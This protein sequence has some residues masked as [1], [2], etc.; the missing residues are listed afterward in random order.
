CNGRLW[1]RA[2]SMW[3]VLH[4]ACSQPTVPMQPYPCSHPTHAATQPTSL[5]KATQPMQ[6]YQ[7]MQPAYP[8]YPAYPAVMR[9]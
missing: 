4:S 6:P 9:T 5:Q 1:G 3:G 2:V 7:P 8:A